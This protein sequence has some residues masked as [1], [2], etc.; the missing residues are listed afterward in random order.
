MRDRLD[1]TEQHFCTGLNALAESM[2]ALFKSGKARDKAQYHQPQADHHSHLLCRKPSHLP[3]NRW[4]DRSPLGPLLREP[5][6]HINHETFLCSEQSK[7]RILCV[8]ELLP[9]CQRHFNEGSSRCRSSAI[10]KQETYS[11]ELQRDAVSLTRLAGPKV[12]LIDPEIR[13]ARTP[14]CEASA[15]SPLLPL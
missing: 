1:V 10:T 3:R 7:H 13:T 14:Q 9:L 6:F 15:T 12:M 11:V 5:E 4:T 2:N 8:W